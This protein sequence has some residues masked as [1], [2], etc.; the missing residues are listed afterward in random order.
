M[1]TEMPVAWVTG[2]VSGLGV[3]IIKLLAQTGYR[4]ATN[5]RRSE[6]KAATLQDKMKADGYESLIV[7]GDVSESRD[8]ERMVSRIRSEWGRIDVLVCTAGP[9]IF[10]RTP[11]ANFRQ[12][13]WHEMIA[14]NLS[15]VFYCTQ[16][17]LPDMR[18]A[19]WGRII[20]FGFPDVEHTPAW[21]GY[22]AYAAAKAG[23]ASLTKTLA[24]EE[25]EYG[26]TANMV[27][28]GDIRH[29]YKEAPISA[30]RGKKESK[31]PVGRPGTGEDIARVI[32]F[33]TERE[34]DFITGAVIDVG[35]GF[36]NHDF[37]TS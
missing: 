1:K 33:L 9:L 4:V 17:V 35:G 22:G 37:S 24:L 23:V 29:P 2:G 32:R 18:A 20:T 34:S 14:G 25:G 31:N 21:K 11:L 30:A 5:Y 3:Q 12:E 13:Q 19:G 10:E 7:Q 8:V 27:C 6:D 28:P 36:D 16:A 26:I 15:S